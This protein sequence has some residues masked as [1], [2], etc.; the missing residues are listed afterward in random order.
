MN[1]AVEREIITEADWEMVHTIEPRSYC[2]CVP[3]V[4]EVALDEESDAAEA[5]AN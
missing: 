5:D 2:T 1:S 4:E 3:R